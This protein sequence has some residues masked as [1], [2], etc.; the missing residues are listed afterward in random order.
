MEAVH[1]GKNPEGRTVSPGICNMWTKDLDLKHEIIQMYEHATR[2]YLYIILKHGLF[3]HDV[4]V[5][6][7][8]GE[9]WVCLRSYKFKCNDL[10]LSQII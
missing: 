5:K 9:N 1:S 3:E 10:H 6:N 2:K 8:N 7:H 4:N